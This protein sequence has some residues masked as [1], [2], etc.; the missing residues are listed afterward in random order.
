MSSSPGP[1]TPPLKPARIVFGGL[2]MG[3]ANLVPGVSGGTM[4]LAM[5]LYD[6]FISALA[7]LSRLRFSRDAIV[8]LGLIGLGAVGALVGLSGIAVSLVTH[9]RWIMYS[10]FIGMTLGGA[11]EL[12]RECKPLRPGAWVAFLSCFALMATLAWGLAG[13]QVPETTIVLVFMG[14][15]G[16]SSMIL[17][18][19][20]GSYML[21]IFGMYDV[22]VGSL[23]ASALKEDP[24][25]CLAVIAPVG[26]GAVLGMGLLSNLLKSMLARHS[27]LSHSALLGLLL[28]SVLGLWPFSEP[29]HADMAHKPFR[30]AVTL[31]VAG[32]TREQVNEKYEV[33]FS[34]ERADELRATY[35]GKSAGDLKVIGDEL[36][37]FDPTG[38]QIGMALG[39]FLLGLSITR[40]LG[41]GQRRE[42][43]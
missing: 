41:R 15:L 8:F 33:E 40:L 37:R 22:V 12:L 6:R 39:L 20:S 43:R 35:A 19:I 24:M 9:S 1:Q 11:P 32:G 36:Q 18:G 29:V 10:L 23:S 2:L 4:I 27:V 16:A 5:G 7:D 34:V 25:A 14:V 17:P 28:G 42:T 3:L 31:L 13:A 38:K 26:V 30:K 21:L